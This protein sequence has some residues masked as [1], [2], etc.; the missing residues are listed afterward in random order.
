LNSVC[1]FRFYAI[2]CAAPHDTSPYVF[3]DMRVIQPQGSN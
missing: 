2:D 3:A 1:H